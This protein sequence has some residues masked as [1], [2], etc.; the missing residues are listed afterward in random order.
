MKRDYR[1]ITGRV[2]NSSSN[3]WIMGLVYALAQ[4]TIAVSI[5]NRCVLAFALV[6]HPQRESFA[7][8][9]ALSTYPHSY[10]QKKVMHMR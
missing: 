3:Y 2:P 7:V 6:F 5:C 10:P 9:L 1:V 4:D 8:A